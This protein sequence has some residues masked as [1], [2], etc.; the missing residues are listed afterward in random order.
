M[1]RIFYGRRALADLER[2]FEF[3]AAEDPQR[4]AEAVA[5]VIDA[6]TVLERHPLIGRPLP[7]NLRELVIAHGRAGYVALYRLR[8]EPA[9]IEVLSIRHQREAGF[10]R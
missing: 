6:I 8:R 9:Q 4:A 1:A 3:L 5:L 7:G 2:L 10:S